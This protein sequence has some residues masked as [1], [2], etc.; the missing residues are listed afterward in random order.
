MLVLSYL[1]PWLWREL[2]LVI[3]ASV[4]VAT[5]VVM[6]LMPQRMVSI[7]AT[8]LTVPLLA[9]FL[10][11]RRWIIPLGGLSALTLLVLSIVPPAEV[12][13]ASD[14]I[15]M[16]MLVVMTTGLVWVVERERKRWQDRVNAQNMELEAAAKSAEEAA[17]SRAKFLATMSHEIRTPM[18]GVL[19][20]TDALLEGELN[21]E[22]R[23]LAEVVR[24]SGQLLLHVLNDI[25]DLSRLESGRVTLEPRPT[26][27][28][29]TVERVVD[30]H[31]E[32]ANAMGLRLSSHID[33]RVPAWVLIDDTR[34]S[35]ILMNLV[36][37]GLKFTSEGGVH[38]EVH[39]TD[40]GIR[41]DVLDT[42][43]GIDPNMVDKLFQPFEQAEA[44]TQRR[45][46]GTGLGL[47]IC[48]SMI[49]LMDGRIG[50]EPTEDGSRFWFSL[51]LSVC[52]PVEAEA[53]Y[54]VLD[55]T[56]IRVL[57]AE[58]NPINRMVAQRALESM[59]ARPTIVEDGQAAVRAMG[60]GPWD[61]VLMDCHM[62]HMDGFEA[63]RTI[64]A[65]GD[66]PRIP[67]LALTASVTEQDRRA[68]LHAGMDDVVGKPFDRKELAETIRRWASS[69]RATDDMTET[70]DID[71]K[72]ED[73]PPK[74]G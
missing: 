12:S 5:G 16:S 68:A 17:E 20:L 29:R 60:E 61:I 10:S 55:L 23:A 40:D 51:P 38:V 58:D 41:V 53:T 35:Q 46:G 4:M 3:A 74:R 33:P 71:A 11:N 8:F 42:G 72:H 21:E 30:L 34:L 19:G 67:I 37:N 39:P 47:A 56:G 9:G 52:D 7:P 69:E 1:R 6:V 66:L 43:I 14:L 18:N 25:L 32:P 73:C 65:N 59:G 27:L 22:Q 44:S 28:A 64:R 31:R 45:F 48:A 50:A 49:A 36:S 13:E 26:S 24:D 62:P 63:T 15:A 2:G 57:V 54:G 70:E